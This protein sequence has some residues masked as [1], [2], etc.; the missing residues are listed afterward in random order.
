MNLSRFISDNKAVAAIEFA[1]IVPIL[2]ALF[3]GGFEITRYVLIY[4]K[5]S[6]T[7]SSISD[8]ISRSNELYE[9]DISNSFNAIEHL[10]AP[11]YVEGEVKV[12]ISSI[13]Y[14]GSGNLLNWQR[15]GGGTMNVQSQVG[16]EGDYV[17]LPTDFYLELNEDTIL[18][19]VYF[20][21]DSLIG[22]D[23][24]SNGILIKSRYTHP[25]LGALTEIKDD[26]GN[27]GC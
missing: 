26:G 8:L 23:F 14:D 17:S 10:L 20:Q 21:Y 15:C 27:T 9:N 3:L 16:Q 12:I 22:L 2:L 7:T 25:R 24:V 1:L 6:K 18:A 5:V 19:E 11:Y 4:Q 13:M